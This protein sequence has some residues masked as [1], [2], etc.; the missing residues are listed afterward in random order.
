M[1]TPEEAER[2]AER[3]VASDAP[4][5]E[6]TVQEF[7][8]GYV[9]SARRPSGAPPLFGQG[10]GIIDK[11][12]AELSV[13]PELPIE[14]VMNQFRERQARRPP[15]EST[16][17]GAEQARWDMDHPITV[18]TRTNLS[19]AGPP[20]GEQMWARSVVGDARPYHH[21]LVIDFLHNRLAAEHRVRGFERCSEAAAIS[22][23]LHAE[24]A[25]RRLYGQPPVTLD[26]ARTSMFANAAMD[27]YRIRE[28]ADP[29]DG[30]DIVHCASCVLLARHFGL[31]LDDPLPTD[32]PAIRWSS[33]GTDRFPAE[34]TQVLGAAGWASGRRTDV[35]G[36]LDFLR[37]NADPDAA[38]I[39]TFDAATAV[40]A[41]FGGLSVDQ[42]GPGIDLRRRAF[43]IDPTQA[44][45]TGDTL[46]DLGKRLS[47]R[48][49][50]IGTDGNQDSVLAVDETGR[51]YAI[52]H[53]GTW[54]LGDTIDAALV[55]L[56]TGIQPLRL[57]SRG[58]WCPP[59]PNAPH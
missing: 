9:V 16:W 39:E 3:W 31:T 47:T 6:S 32:A 14:I 15:R 12:T 51:T 36:V 11:E 41:E 56:V 50:P 28:L 37:E 5:A 59:P 46:A 35:A 23:V 19:I 18:A 55:T 38:P 20:I 58:N 21:R 29:L 53:A 30:Q 25:R 44:Y 40:I 43:T 45:G 2:I 57:D 4:G 1:I 13:W 42:D 27:S 49:F 34:V 8:L 7:E 10:L 26:E 22:D 33:A 48:L 54:H 24:D 17:D 52:D